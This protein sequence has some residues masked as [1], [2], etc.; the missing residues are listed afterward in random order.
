[1][2]TRLNVANSSYSPKG[3]KLFEMVREIAFLYALVVELPLAF[4]RNRDQLKELWK[5]IFL[6]PFLVFALFCTCVVGIDTCNLS[7]DVFT[8]YQVKVVSVIKREHEYRTSDSV[9]VREN[10]KL[11]KLH[12]APGYIDVDVGKSYTIRVFENSR[13]AIA[14]KV[15]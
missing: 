4:V 11:L 5:R 13:I 15:E 8:G 3:L 2:L 6:T 10:F 1:M 12:L 14:I 9:W 7:K